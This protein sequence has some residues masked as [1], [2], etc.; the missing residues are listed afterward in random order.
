[1]DV[2]TSLRATGSDVTLMD[3]EQLKKRFPWIDTTGVHGAI[4][5]MKDQ[6]WFDPWSYLVAMKKKCVALGVDVLDGEVAAFDLATDSAIERVHIDKKTAG[7]DALVR[8]TV[9]TSKVV[10]A[11]GPWASKLL[12]ACGSFDYPV[13]PRCVGSERVSSE[14]VGCC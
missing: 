14:A 12:E 3:P 5:G 1:M 13:K 4:L 10:N 8:R 11:A 7:S 2:S 9:S 6:G